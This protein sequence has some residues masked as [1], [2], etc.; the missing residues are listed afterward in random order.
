MTIDES[1]TWWVGSE[2]RDIEGFLK[3]FADDGYEVRAFR[4]AHCT[5]GSDRFSLEA[6][7]NE[8]AARRTCV[9]CGTEYFICDSAD[10]WQDAE[11]EPWSCIECKSKH[12]NVGCGF[13]LRANG[14]V[15]WIYVGARCARCG[16]L[17]CYA[18]WKID[19]EPS[20]HLLDRV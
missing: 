5:C 17:G 2:P 15:R 10:S 3:A 4:L 14:E 7:D 18:G 16:I 8:G 11:P 12:A 6:D 9:A 19:Y 1:G 13:A 20:T